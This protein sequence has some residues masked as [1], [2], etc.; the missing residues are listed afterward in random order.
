MIHPFFSTS[1]LPQNEPQPIVLT[2]FEKSIA[3]ADLFK[4]QQYAA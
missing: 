1:Y 3:K 2:L 4:A